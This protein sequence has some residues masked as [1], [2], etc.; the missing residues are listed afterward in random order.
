VGCEGCG[1]NGNLRVNGDRPRN[2]D[3]VLDGTTIAAPVFGG[4]AINPAIDSIQEFR[5]EANSM[6]A[7]YGKAGGGVLVAVTKSGTN[8]FHGSGYECARNERLNA[9]NFFEDRA[10][11]K[12]RSASMSS[13][14]RSAARS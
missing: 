1:N 10:S 4:Q 2:Q 13:A 3:Y 8:Q 11:P 5:I 9:R 12:N 14:A 7:E 6:S